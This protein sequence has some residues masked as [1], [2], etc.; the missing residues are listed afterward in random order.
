V[1]S[2]RSGASWNRAD[3]LKAIFLL[4]RQILESFRSKEALTK[5]KQAAIFDQQPARIL[6]NIRVYFYFFYL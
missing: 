3:P 6:L 1:S 4:L 2:C 5:P